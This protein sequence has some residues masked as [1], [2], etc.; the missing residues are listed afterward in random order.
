MLYARGPSRA[1]WIHIIVEMSDSLG[2]VRSRW[3]LFLVWL[4]ER[5]P[6]WKDGWKVVFV[7][8]SRVVQLNLRKL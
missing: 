4:L 5:C 6:V 7:R 8:R 1:E 3:F 2:R